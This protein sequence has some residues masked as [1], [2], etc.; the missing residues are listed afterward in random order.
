MA[1]EALTKSLLTVIGIST[2]LMSLLILRKL[3]DENLSMTKMKLKPESTVFD[4][5]LIMG[6]NILMFFG[7]MMYIV[8]V[9]VNNDGLWIF[10]KVVGAVF[11]LSYAVVL[12]RWWDRF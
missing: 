1:T 5:K 10:S 6:A 12:Y 2:G 8:G 11:G 4:F 3:Q 7:F 9:L